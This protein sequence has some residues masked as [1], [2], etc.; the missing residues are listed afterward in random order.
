[1]ADLYARRWG[2]EVFFRTVKQSYERSKMRS[3]T[4]ENAKQEIQWTLLAVWIALS[5]GARSIPEGRR[6]S[7]IGVL[8]V[9][10]RLVVAVAESSAKKTDVRLSLSECV[11]A[12]ETGRKRQTGEPNVEPISAELQALANARLG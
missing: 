2:V 3:R 8:R 11:L 9:F 10:P 1:M 4:P 5:E 6:L 12:D 7:P